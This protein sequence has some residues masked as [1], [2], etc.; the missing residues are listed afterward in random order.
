MGAPHK[1]ELLGLSPKSVQSGKS[2]ASEQ[3]S[4]TVGAFTPQKL[5]STES[6][7]FSYRFADFCDKRV[8][9]KNVNNTD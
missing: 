3:A 2:A 8:R 1:P 7:G 9:D 4:V 5:V 6:Q